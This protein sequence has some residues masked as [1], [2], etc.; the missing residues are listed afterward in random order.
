MRRRVHLLPLLCLLLGS[1]MLLASRPALAQLSPERQAIGD[2]QIAMQRMNDRLLE[3]NGRIE[4]LENENRRLRAEVQRLRQDTEQRLGELEGGSADPFAGLAGDGAD[5]GETTPPPTPRRQP[6]PDPDAALSEG[7]GQLTSG[8]LQQGAQN[9][10]QTPDVPATPNELYTFAYNRIRSRDYT[11]AQTAFETFLQR[12]PD[13]E[14]AGKV[15]Y[16][17]GETYYVQGDYNSAARQYATGLQRF[18]QDSRAPD[19][20]YKLGV[21]FRLQGESQRACTAFRSLLRS[22]ANAS[23]ALLSRAEREMQQMRCPP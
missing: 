4:R 1:L 23:R 7:G 8:D 17:F 21:A 19:S 15:H 3:L 2:L 18:P 12:Y 5:G 9:P 16:W 11:G 14:L 6:T 13:H 22:Y 20:L 10:R